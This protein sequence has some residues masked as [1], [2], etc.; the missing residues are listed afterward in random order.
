[1]TSNSSKIEL[2]RKIEGLFGIELLT[3]GNYYDAKKYV[4]C[5]HVNIESTSNSL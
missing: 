4:I 2:P 1:L 5:Y 3:K